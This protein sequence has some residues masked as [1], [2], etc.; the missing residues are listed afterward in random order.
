MNLKTAYQKLQIP[1]GTPKEEAKKAFKKL[2]KQWHPDL[3]KDPQSEAKFKE[4]NEAWQV[5][6]SGRS[7]DPGDNHP[8][9]HGFNINDF[10]SNIGFDFGGFGRQSRQKI[11]HFPDIYLNETLSFKESVLGCKRE[12]KYKR[13]GKCQDCQGLGEKTINNGCNKCQ[14]KGIFTSQKGNVIMQQV[15]PDC[16]GKINSES[17]KPCNATG[18]IEMDGVLKIDIPPTTDGDVIDIG[19]YGHFVGS[20]M[21]MDRSTSVLLKI[22]VIP[23][24]GLSL[25]EDGNV[26]SLIQI[27]L[28][29]ALTGTKKI[30]PTIDGDKEISIPKLSKN[31]D[32]VILPKLG[33][34][35]HANQRNI[36]EVIYPEDVSQLINTLQD[37]E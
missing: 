32:E 27:S 12:L 19:G 4:I 24:K 2:A 6:E 9:H 1:E 8:S 21:G 28:L 23:Q 36:I 15:C 26:L 34:M 25:D 10:I 13:H 16:K 35:R 20:M 11:H 14:G 22:K 5:I 29:E 7:S 17:C 37:K 3:N 33:V 31:K 30:V 18:T